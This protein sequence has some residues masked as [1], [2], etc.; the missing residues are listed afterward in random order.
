MIGILIMFITALILAILLVIVDNKLN[1]RD[2]KIE[3][4]FDK[5]PKYNCGACGFGN[6]ENMAKEIIKNKKAYLKCKPLRGTEKKILEEYL[7]L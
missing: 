4:I 6:C 3:D 7:K 2:K 1:Y 5:L